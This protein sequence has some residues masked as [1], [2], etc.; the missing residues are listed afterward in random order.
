M[1]NPTE[2]P[3]DPPDWRALDAWLAGSAT[4]HDLDTVTRWMAADPRHAAFAESLRA[5]AITRDATR[6]PDVDRGWAA[7]QA[8][9]RAAERERTVIAMP[10]SRLAG[11]YRRTMGVGIAAAVT[12]IVG[13]QA[14]ARST[15]ELTAPTGTQVT[16]M[17]PDGT[18]ITLDAGSHASYRRRFTSS[19]EI[20]LDGS[21][22][23]VVRHDASHPF[24]VRAN[25]GVITD[26]GTRFVVNAYRELDHVDV[27]V[28]E[29]IVTLGAAD[30]SRT[31]TLTAGQSARLVTKG[32]HS[33]ER[34]DDGTAIASWTTGS[35]VFADVPL[36]DVVVR[37]GREYGTPIR[38]ADSA[39][40]SRRVT[41]NLHGESVTGALDAI[42]VALG[43]RYARTG[44]TITVS[45]VR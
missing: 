37:L 22:L 28:T 39:L 7:V 30:D 41:T 36:G 17:L 21:G 19:R 16:R 11:R 43:L 12:A 13:W 31:L 38:L 45:A 44:D 29:G 20:S 24:R 15:V 26:V 6:A 14:Y 2:L 18:T 5:V 35:L 9:M 33:L 40:A 32:A 27:A 42:T 3:D 1:S 8:R 4:P 23:F 25:G 34:R 10:R